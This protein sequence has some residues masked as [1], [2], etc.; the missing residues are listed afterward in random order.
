MATREHTYDVKVVWTGNRGQGTTSYT[1]YDRNHEISHAGKPVLPGS[2]DPTFRGDGARYN[3]EELLVASLSACHMLWYLHL[4]AVNGVVIIDYQD[5]ATGTMSDNG[6]GGEFVE[7]TLHPRVTIT[8]ASDEKKA[9]EL[10]HGAHQRCY[11]ASS[12][13]FPVRNEPEIV[14]AKQ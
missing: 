2:S 14:K 3:P 11:I 7:V 13:K 5:H 4:C 12:V 6:D 8:A 10:H 1:S 9:R